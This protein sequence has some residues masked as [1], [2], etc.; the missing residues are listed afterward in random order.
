MYTTP[1][2]VIVEQFVSVNYNSEGSV[3]HIN[4]V[5]PVKQIDTWDIGTPKCAISKILHTYVCWYLVNIP[6]PVHYTLYTLAFS[7]DLRCESGIYITYNTGT[8]VLPDIYALA[9]GHCTP[10]GVM[11]I[12]Q[13]NHF[14]LC[15]NYILQ[16]SIMTSPLAWI[17]DITIYL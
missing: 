5:W 1:F 2:S 13:A 15:Y 7:F 17:R 11:H 3:S 9:L 4:S 10:S 16:S 6:E 12:Y 14:Y 8:C